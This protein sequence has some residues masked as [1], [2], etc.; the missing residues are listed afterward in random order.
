MASDVISPYI[1]IT[2]SIFFFLLIFVQTST[3][4]AENESHTTTLPHITVR[5]AA[6]INNNNNMELAKPKKAQ[7]NAKPTTDHH[8]PL[9]AR[10]RG[11]FRTGKSSL[12]Q[13]Q[14]QRIFNTSAHEVP[15]GP[16]PISNR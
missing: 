1:I 2:I 8:L 6:A 3:D 13:A 11:H 5:N 7:A 4:E 9:M 14:Q 12:P 10:K 15:S 16:N